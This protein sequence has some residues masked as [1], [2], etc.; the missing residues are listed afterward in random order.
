[1]NGTG[2]GARQ[3]R[4]LLVLTFAVIVVVAI[5]SGYIRTAVANLSPSG[6]EDRRATPVASETASPTAGSPLATPAQ[7][8]GIAAQ[9]RTARVFT[10]IQHQVGVLRELPQLRQ[11]PLT[12]PTPG[13]MGGLLRRLYEGRGWAEKAEPYVLL[14]LLPRAEVS[15]E[16]RATSTV[17]VPEQGQIYVANGGQE[18]SADDQALVVHAYAHALQD[19]HFGLNA[20]GSAAAT[21]DEALALDALLEG[22]AM[23]VAGLYRYGDLAAIDWDNLGELVLMAERPSY[24]EGLDQNPA[25]DRLAHFPNWE[26]RQFVQA[27]YESGSWEAVDLAYTNPPRSTEEILHPERYGSGPSGLAD[28][29]VPDLGVALGDGWTITWEDTFG[30]FVTG[31]YLGLI[32]PEERAWE[33]VDGWA[34]DAFVLWEREDGGRLWLWRSLWDSVE[35][36]AEFESALLTLAPHSAPPVR[37]AEPPAGLSGHWYETGKGFVHFGRVGRYVVWIVAPDLNT[38]ANVAELLP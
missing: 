8:D 1:V 32:L 15:I 33:A 26:G 5:L 27:L 36:A 17:Y 34:G 14:G 13:E 25:F 20:A 28:V 18:R 31:L 9:V 19:Q 21:T 22:D 12:F 23:L 16:A 24:G 35:E 29:L 2:Q 7:S 6:T 11:V 38:A 30:E 37:R 3:R 10:Q 4:I